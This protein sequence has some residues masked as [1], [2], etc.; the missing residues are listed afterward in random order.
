M[1]TASRT[2]RFQSLFLTGLVEITHGDPLGSLHLIV[3]ARHR[4][5]AF[6]AERQTVATEDFRIDENTQRVALFRNI[7]HDHAQMYIDLR[8]SETDA[9]ASYMVSAMSAANW[10]MLSSI[11]STGRAIFCRR[12]SGKRK[13]G[14]R[15]MSDRNKSL[16]AERITCRI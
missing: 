2:F 8:C 3:N 1:Q 10:R 16:L 13:M 6:F 15:A 11:L 12:G 14:N 4:Q 9:G 7:D 5:A